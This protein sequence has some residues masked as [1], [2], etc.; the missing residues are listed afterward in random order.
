MEIPLDA[1]KCKLCGLHIPPCTNPHDLTM[2]LGLA[3]R[4]GK[5]A[6]LLALPESFS[7]QNLSREKVKEEEPAC[8]PHPVGQE[9]AG[10]GALNT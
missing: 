4:K 6:K 2:R 8:T 1:K 9:T 5:G 7:L 3:V 10:P